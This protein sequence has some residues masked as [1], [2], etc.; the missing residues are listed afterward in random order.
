MLATLGQMWPLMWDDFESYANNAALATVWHAFD[1]YNPALPMVLNTDS[2]NI[3]YDGR[4]V[5]GT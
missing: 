2:E 4:S 3:V 5:S 1:A